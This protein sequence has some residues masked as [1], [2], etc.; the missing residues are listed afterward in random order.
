[1]ARRVVS[2]RFRLELAHTGVEMNRTPRKTGQPDKQAPPVAPAMPPS[3]ARPDLYIF[4]KVARNISSR[5]D[6]PLRL[7]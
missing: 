1:M 2:G 4:V 5:S 6:N 7:E 3:A